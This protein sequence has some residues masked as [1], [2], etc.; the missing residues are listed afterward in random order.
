MRIK[1][2]QCGLVSGSVL[3]SPSPPGRGARVTTSKRRYLWDLLSP[4]AIRVRGRF[5]HW[6]VGAIGTKSSLLSR[7]SRCS[8]AGKSKWQRLR[9]LHTEWVGSPLNRIKPVLCF[10][11]AIGQLGRLGM[12][13]RAETLA[14]V[15]ITSFIATVANAEAFSVKCRIYFTYYLSFETSLKRAVYEVEN[16]PAYKGEIM[17][18]IDGKISFFIFFNSRT[19]K[20]SGVWSARLQEVTWE[21]SNDK[22]A[23]CEPIE[24]RPALARYERIPQ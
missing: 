20:A 8:S 23:R 18:Q 3:I 5:A 17:Q 15:F 2:D 9:A 10:F 4:R 24:L 13:F 7:G 12:C 21:S 22:N 19:S 14:L 11:L 1:L 16:G 6:T